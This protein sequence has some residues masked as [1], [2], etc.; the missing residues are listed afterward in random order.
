VGLYSQVIFPR[1]CDLVLSR[2]I[3]AEHRRL[4]LASAQGDVLEIGFGT[5]LN[6]PLYPER[7]RRIATADPS[8]GMQRRSG[9]RVHRSRIDVRRHIAAAEQLPFKEGSFDCVV[10]TFTLCSV[11]DPAHVL[12]EVVRVLRPGGR[13]LLLE[14]GLSPEPG[15]ARWQRRLNWIEARLAGGCRLDR[16]IRQLVS[17]QPFSATAIDEFYLPR[18]PRTHGY[19][20]RGMAL[21]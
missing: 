21:K 8:V 19:W 4:L 18:V 1:L 17:A 7:V 16:A 3:V 6:L 14:H 20:Y 12:S 2:P 11:A 5:G 10:S 15:V 13:F 9:E